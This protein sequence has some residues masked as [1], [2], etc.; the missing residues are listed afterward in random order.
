MPFRFVMLGMD[1]THAHG[2]VEQVAR[3]PEEFQLTG[4][5]DSSAA[6][7]ARRRE[8][9]LPLLPELEFFDDPGRLLATRP[10]GVIVEG[11]V[12]QNLRWARF[13][14]ER[15]FP[16]L[17]EKPA[18]ND[19]VEFEEVVRLAQSRGL[20]LQML[21]LFRSM[22]AVLQM[23][24]LAES[25][26]LGRIYMF[27]ARLSK[28]LADYEWNAN[29]FAWHRGGIFFE[30]AGH[31]IDMMVTMLGRPANVT[32]FLGHHHNTSGSFVDNGI[33]VFEFGGAWGI[34]E[35]PALETAP[36]SRRFE[37]YGTEG[38]CVIPH[39]GSGHLENNAKQPLQVSLDGEGWRTLDLDAAVLQVADLREFVACVRDG[40]APRYSLEHDVVVQEALLRASDCIE[41]RHLQ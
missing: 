35:V 18:G 25:G 26:R 8:E 30:M 14:L 19:L 3:H 12:W 17:L 32:P 10:D 29:S 5:Y 24:E 20:H 38:A 23:L 41:R 39:L 37:V 16:V 22:T 28:D 34:V 1:H 13:S 6:V 21:Y 11:T 31:A 33:A 7:V 36:N 40:K 4:A 15:G 9:W 27:R 2:I